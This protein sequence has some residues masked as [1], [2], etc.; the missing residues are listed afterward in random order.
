MTRRGIYFENEDMKILTNL[1][2]KTGLTKSALLRH[3]IHNSR[4]IEFSKTIENYNNQ[5]DNFLD[6][7]HKIGININQIAYHLNI[8]I[9]K[10][11]ESKENIQK[12]MNKL[13][14]LLEEYKNKFSKIKITPKKYKTIK[15][16]N[17]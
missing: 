3:L 6:E 17:E 2:K 15:A 13:I 16:N 5:I 10:E 14:P 12:Q 8:D 7:I 4:Y 11:A 1:S 9:T